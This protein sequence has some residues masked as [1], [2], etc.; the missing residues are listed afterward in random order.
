[1]FVLRLFN[2]LHCRIGNR[3]HFCSLWMFS[4]F[5]R[6]T[7]AATNNFKV[8][9]IKF[10]YIQARTNQ[11]R[12][13]RKQKQEF[14][15]EVVQQSVQ[16]FARRFNLKALFDRNRFDFRHVA[17]HSQAVLFEGLLQRGAPRMKPDKPKLCIIFGVIV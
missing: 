6:F 8:D 16:I 2:H 17:K 15:Q 13:T 11:K 10:C 3:L 5:K 1:M 4:D 12:F 9:Q 7:E 14:V